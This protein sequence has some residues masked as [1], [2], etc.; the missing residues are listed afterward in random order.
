ANL[1]HE[2]GAALREGSAVRDDIDYERLAALA[3]ALDLDIAALQEIGSPRAARRVFPESDY[4]LVMSSRYEPGAE[5]QDERDI[6]T[7]VAFAK[8][9]FPAIPTTAT[10]EAI[11]IPNIDFDRDGTPSIRDTRAGIVAEIEVA[12]QPVHLLNVHLKSS[13]HRWSLDPVVDE[14]S[15]TQS[16]FRSRFDCRTLAAQAA[17][18]E[19]WIEQQAAQ[20]IPT[21][22]LGDFNREMNASNDDGEPIDHLWR[23]LNDGTPGGLTLIKG[24]DGIDTVCWPNHDPRFEE[25]IDFVV[26]DA[27]LADLATVQEPEKM[28]MGFETDPRYDDRDRQRLSD[29]CPVVTAV[30]W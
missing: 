24:P 30:E 22:V 18:L 27:Q 29:H 17:V 10:L 14:S 7:A 8:D 4:H 11:A 15:T 19:S 3:A 20:G 5:D 28:S 26:Y 1:H 23:N 21:I 25:H 6:Y 9:R 16:P 12:G 13:C 2:S